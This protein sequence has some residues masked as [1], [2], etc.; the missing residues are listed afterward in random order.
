MARAEQVQG[1]DAADAVTETAED[2]AV[3]PEPPADSQPEI[4]QPQ[5]ELD[6]W[7]PEDSD[8]AP[9][10]TG[11]GTAGADAP[12]IDVPPPPEVPPEDAA[13]Q[14]TDDAAAVDGVTPGPAEPAAPA[15]NRKQDGGGRSGSASPAPSTAP[16]KGRE[17]F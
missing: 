14:R 11:G 4:A 5:G 16:S 8:M 2:D 12:G 1:A 7:P 17:W 15:G 6:F 9:G 3:A 10:R 13:A